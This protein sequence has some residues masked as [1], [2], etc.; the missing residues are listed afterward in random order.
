MRFVEMLTKYIEIVY[1]YFYI[2]WNCFF[3]SALKSK[4]KCQIK[5][6]ICLSVYMHLWLSAF[7]LVTKCLFMYI[8]VIAGFSLILS[9]YSQQGICSYG[10]SDAEM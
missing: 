10:K 5:I 3:L 1:F 2:H 7:I 8:L 6:H 9:M 4:K